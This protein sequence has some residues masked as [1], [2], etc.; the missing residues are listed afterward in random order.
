MQYRLK[1]IRESKKYKAD[2]MASLIGV[3]VSAYIKKENG[4]S[5]FKMNEMF[6]IAQ[7]FNMRIED[8]FTPDFT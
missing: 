4:Q 7:E 2:K 3:T 5:Q 6:L 1:A 8:I